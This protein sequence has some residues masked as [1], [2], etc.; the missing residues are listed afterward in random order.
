MTGNEDE[1]RVGPFPSW[2]A[3]YKTVVVYGVLVIGILLILT[4]VLSF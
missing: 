2:G 3:L 1:G 4:R